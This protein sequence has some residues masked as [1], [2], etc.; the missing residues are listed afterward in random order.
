MEKAVLAVEAFLK[1]PV[2]CLAVG[3][4]LGHV[5]K[6]DLEKHPNV[7]NCRTKKLPGSE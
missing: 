7:E 2:A 5:K 1:A 6:V 3:G 4:K